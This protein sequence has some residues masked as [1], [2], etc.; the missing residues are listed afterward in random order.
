[1]ISTTIT[2]E[3]IRDAM[4]AA[5]VA[6]QRRDLEA[7]GII[8]QGHELSP[9]VIAHLLASARAE[10]KVRPIDVLMDEVH[11]QAGRTIGLEAPQ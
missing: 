11:R 1:M 4:R 8:E 3:Q 6:E 7:A 9:P 2:T 5:A 10:G